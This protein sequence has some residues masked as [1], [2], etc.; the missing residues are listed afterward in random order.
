MLSSLFFALEIEN[1]FYL[2]IPKI[3]AHLGGLLS[4]PFPTVIT[5]P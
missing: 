5:E 1:L 4:L 2:K 3:S